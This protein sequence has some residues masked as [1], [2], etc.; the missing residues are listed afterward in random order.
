M[1]LD[2]LHQY[3]C[4]NPFNYLEIHKKNVFSCC[5]SWLPTPV[6]DPNNLS[7]I[8]N[9]TVLKNIQNSI[10]DGT[11]SYCN[12]ELCPYLSELIYNE[13]AGEVFSIKTETAPYKNG[14]SRIGLCFDSSCNLS[15]PSCRKSVIIEDPASLEIIDK[16]MDDIINVFGGTIKQLSI[17]GTAEPFVSK[18]FRNFLINFNKEKFPK[19]GAIYLQT[20]GTLLNEEMWNKIANSQNIIYAVSVSIDAATKETYNIVRKGGNWNVLLENLSFI[21][22]LNKMKYFSFVVQKANYKEMEL[23]Y[24]LICNLHPVG[25]F[26][27]YFSKINDWDVMGE[28]EYKMAQVWDEEHPEFEM[29]LKELEKVAGKYNVTTNM[30]DIIEKYSLL[31]TRTRLI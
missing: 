23:F 8:W 14:P 17:A 19:L 18:T 4:L 24:N 22:S 21:S 27:V 31:K 20:N 2:L 29:F 16:T 9:G 10:I 11:Y 1:N 15:C 26:C 5:P 6:G 30:N 13:N 12:K 25:E 3:V 7:E 28:N